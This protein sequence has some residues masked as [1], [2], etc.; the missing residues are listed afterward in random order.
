MHNI[1][2]DKILAALRHLINNAPPLNILLVFEIFLQIAAL[3]I[4]C[5]EVA[6]VLC[7]IDVYKFDNVG[8]F[9]LSHNSDFVVE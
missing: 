2:V 4:L 7:V 5:D 8:V 6:V 1:F 3:A 9:Q